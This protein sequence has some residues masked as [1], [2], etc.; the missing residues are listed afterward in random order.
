MPER[1]NFIVRDSWNGNILSKRMSKTNA[2]KLKEELNEKS[3]N[4]K[5]LKHMGNTPYIQSYYVDEVSE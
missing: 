1:K 3:R 2:E 4:A 5:P